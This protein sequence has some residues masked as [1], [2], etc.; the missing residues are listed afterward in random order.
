MSVC[1]HLSGNWKFEFEFL[2]ITREG[3]GEGRGGGRTGR[4]EGR[5][6]EG[7]YREGVYLVHRHLPAAELTPSSPLGDT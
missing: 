7:V 6:D 4:H 3:L 5:E 1:R 2:S